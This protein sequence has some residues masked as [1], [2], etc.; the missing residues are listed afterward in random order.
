MPS[1]YQPENFC[2]SGASGTAGASSV[3]PSAMIL[4][5]I[6]VP[7]TTKVYVQSGV[8]SGRIPP[9]MENAAKSTPSSATTG[10]SSVAGASSVTPNFAYSVRFPETGVSK[11]YASFARSYQ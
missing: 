7:S 5:S 4:V 1:V 11:L 3:S 9:A 2:P 6:V 10:S 8:V